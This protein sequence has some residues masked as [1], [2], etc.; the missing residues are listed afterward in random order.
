MT[1]YTTIEGASMQ[2]PK[3]APL[4]CSRL[5]TPPPHTLTALMHA[6]WLLQ[7]AALLQCFGASLLYLLLPRHG[8]HRSLAGF[9]TRSKER[10][11]ELL[12]LLQ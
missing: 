6:Q 1:E 3:T 7:S 5:R 2:Q 11:A 9:L 12:L 10:T 4:F 8:M